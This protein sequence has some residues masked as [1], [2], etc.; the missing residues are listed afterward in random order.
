MKQAQVLRA[1]M[2]GFLTSL[3]TYIKVEVVEA[4]WDGFCQTLDRVRNLDEL[5]GVH[6]HL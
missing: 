2:A 6:G 5:I 4:A 1:A 3:Q